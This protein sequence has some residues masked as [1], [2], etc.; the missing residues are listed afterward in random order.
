MAGF[1]VAR[2]IKAVLVILAIAA[3][4]FVLIRLAPGDPASVLA[5]EAGATD[6]N[7]VVELRRQFGLD[8]PMWKQLGLYLWKV[9][10][11]DFGYSYRNHVP[12]MQLILERL[13]ATL[14]LMASSFV[15]SLALGVGFGALAAGVSFQRARWLDALIMALAL[16]FYATPLFWLALMMVIVFS[17][18]LDWLPAFGMESVGANLHGLARVADIGAHLVLPTLALSFFFM[19]VYVRLTRASMMDVMTQDHVRTAFAKGL[20]SWTVLRRHVLRNALLPIVT[21]A[22]LQLGQAGGAV[23]IE[24][25]FAWPGIGRLMFDA[26]LQRDYQLLLGVFLVT[27]ATVIVFNILTDLAYRLVDP[28]IR[29]GAGAR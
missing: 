21:F 11:F 19:S 2:L 12:V 16:L 20:G 23:L 18:K 10:Q 8:E 5:G 4:N 6:P 24:T 26:L 22:G 28:R 17:V 13:P 3:L 25:V 29:I 27:S 15:V 14:L 1:L 7:Y 9:A